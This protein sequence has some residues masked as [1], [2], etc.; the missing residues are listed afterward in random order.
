MKDYLFF[1][2]ETTGRSTK[3]C[4]GLE[5]FLMRCRGPLLMP[6]SYLHHMINPETEIPRQAYEVNHIEQSW[7]DLA[8][9]ESVVL[10][11]VSKFVRP[12][13]I[14]SG[15]NIKRYDMKI[16]ERNC[17]YENEILDT[18]EL[19]KE[20]GFETGK[21]SQPYLF[22]HF[23]PE[24]VER[25]RLMAET[26][27]KAEENGEDLIWTENPGAHRADQDVK[28]C[29]LICLELMKMVPKKLF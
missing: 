24:E 13:D 16:I 7:V 27:A 11:E 17:K 25:R 23:F 3:T 8:D 5:I 26:I 2:M 12:T 22:E 10:E 20:A 19:A 18:L 15:H 29:R 9:V 21:R 6:I 14:L 4:R 1:D 28:D